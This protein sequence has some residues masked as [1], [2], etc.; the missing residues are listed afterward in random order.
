MLNII[1]AVIG[2]NDKA[3]N[4]ISIGAISISFVDLNYQSTAGTVSLAY[5]V[6]SGA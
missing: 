2:I 5:D 1:I 3:A 4:F 6:K